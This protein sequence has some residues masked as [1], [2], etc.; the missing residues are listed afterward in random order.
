MIDLH[1]L[2][3]DIARVPEEVFPGKNPLSGDYWIEPHREKITES[4]GHSNGV[5]KHRREDISLV[6]V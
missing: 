1:Y 6:S 4:N 3:A 5:E 2:E